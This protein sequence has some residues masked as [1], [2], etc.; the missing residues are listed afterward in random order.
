MTN[1]SRRRR[2]STLSVTVFSKKG[3]PDSSCQE[4]HSQQGNPCFGL[5]FKGH[6]YLYGVQL[7][8]PARHNSNYAHVLY[9]TLAVD[10]T[11]HCFGMRSNIA[12]ALLASLLGVL[13]AG[14]DASL[15]TKNSP[16]LQ[17]DH[18]TYDSLIAK[19]NYTS[20]SSLV[21]SWEIV[22]RTN[23]RSLD[24]RVCCRPYHGQLLLGSCC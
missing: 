9:W 16:V 6:E 12:L 13:P 2:I 20:V 18:K 14:V 5:I 10:G 19:S 4:L 21:R 3:S 15:Y 17:V 7:E 1:R 22:D 24:C 11:D 23:E 8:D